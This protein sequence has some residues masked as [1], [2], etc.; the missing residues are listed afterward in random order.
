MKK[1]LYIMGIDWYWIRQRP[2]IIAEMLS[3]D[4][5]VTVGYYHE[6]FV[7]QQLR[8]EN[9]ELEK[10]FAIPAIPYRDKSKLAFWIQRCFFKKV[11]RNIENYDVIWITNPLLYRY[12][13][14]G[15]QGKI[16]YDCMDDHLALCNDIKI[17]NRI[18]EVET[19]LVRR[20]DLIFTSSV[21]LTK[22]IENLCGKVQPVLIRNGFV[23]DEIHAP[24]KREKKEKNY[25]IGYFGTIAEWFDFSAL[26]DSLEHFPEVEYHLWG[27]VINIEIPKHPRIFMEGVIEHSR[28]WDGM[29]TMDC[30]IMPFK[31]TK[32]I[33]AVDPVKLYEYISMGK[34]IISVYYKEVERFSPFVS[35]YHSYKELNV[36]IKELIQKKFQAVYDERSQQE[37]LK[38]NSW[39]SRYKIIKKE[40]ERS[41]R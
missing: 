41:V 40:V 9:D 35:F 19:A 15:F 39:N 22:K 2:Q 25:K 36:V 21:G 27:P 37:F 6:V 18:N 23:W 13:S 20:A 17:R 5:D 38:E 11:N 1:I 7:R 33:E 16:V 10:S 26:L 32:A 29:K 14:S 12:I 24:V 3:E 34:S 31:V 4:Y 8:T 30:M 28:L